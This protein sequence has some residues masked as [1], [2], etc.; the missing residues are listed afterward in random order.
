[1]SGAP[2]GGSK[3]IPP[4]RKTLGQ[5]KKSGGGTGLIAVSEKKKTGNTFGAEGEKRAGM[6]TRLGGQKCWEKGQVLAAFKSKKTSCGKRTGGYAGCIHLL[7][8]KRQKD[9]AQP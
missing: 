2:A 3:F 4:D 7:C 1:M 8:K 5:R 9:C 6:A